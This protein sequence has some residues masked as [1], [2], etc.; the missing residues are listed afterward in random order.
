M[1]HQVESFDNFLTDL[2]LKAQSC[3]FNDLRDYDS[4]SDSVW[5]K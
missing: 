1:Q 3:N 5:D 2:K 4:G